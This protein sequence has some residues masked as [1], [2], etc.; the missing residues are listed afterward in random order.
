[1]EP[2]PRQS[3]IRTIREKYLLRPTLGVIVLL[4][5]TIAGMGQNGAASVATR[6]FEK[7]IG[8][9]A[10]L[11][12]YERGNKTG[13]QGSGFYI[14]PHL[15]VT[16]A[17]VVGTARSCRVWQDCTSRDSVVQ[18]QLLFAD[19][20]RDVAVVYTDTI[21][22]PLLLRSDVPKAGEAIYAIG[23]PRGMMGTFSA[24]IVSG[25]RSHGVRGIVQSSLFTE[26]GASGGPFIDQRGRIVGMVIAGSDDGSFTLGV[27]VPTIRH[28]L[29]RMLMAYCV[30]RDRPGALLRGGSAY[31][32][33]A[34]LVLC[35]DDLYALGG[36]H[37]PHAFDSFDPSLWTVALLAIGALIGVGVV[38]RQRHLRLLRVKRRRALLNDLEE[39][40]QQ[41]F[42]PEQLF[43]LG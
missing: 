18:G 43:N 33:W 25:L 32:S 4:C 40:S 16:C 38:L 5:A 13:H 37:T 36:G 14:S 22:T 21:A 28:A 42:I 34:N 29:S 41:A 9:T 11:G 15:L 1:M 2:T 35:E 3:P 8:S 24:G 39:S 7:A 27:D 6:V 20:L 17:H 23:T 10:R 30:S 12:V 26:H 31:G 19:S